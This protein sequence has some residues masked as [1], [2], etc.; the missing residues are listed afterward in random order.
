MCVDVDICVMGC[1]AQTIKGGGPPGI[2]HGERNLG[3]T[4]QI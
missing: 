3:I 4:A 1:S 2:V